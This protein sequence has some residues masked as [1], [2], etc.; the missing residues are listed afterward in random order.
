M[1]SLIF[2]DP[3]KNNNSYPLVL[4]VLVLAVLAGCQSKPESGTG[5]ETVSLTTE[6]DESVIAWAFDSALS[7]QDAAMPLTDITLKIK[8]QTFKVAEQAQGEY[9][10]MDQDY[11]N[12]WGVSAAALSACIGGYGG[13]YRVIWVEK[14]GNSLLVKEAW[15]DAESGQEGL[16]DEKVLKTLTQAELKPY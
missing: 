1:M 14:A 7:G 11:R 6:L 10:A 2:F 9:S 13:L 16:F 5:Q 8:D 12:S 3:L 15:S 4:C